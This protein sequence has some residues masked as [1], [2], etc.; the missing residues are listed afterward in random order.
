MGSWAGKGNT[1][2]LEPL[3]AEGLN[4]KE[5]KWQREGS[6][7]MVMGIGDMETCLC[8]QKHLQRGSKKCS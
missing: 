5:D 8:S 6:K 7:E 2:L 4:S 3:V 1:C